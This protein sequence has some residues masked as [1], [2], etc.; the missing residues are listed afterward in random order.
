[1]KVD[2]KKIEMYMARQYMRKQDLARLSGLSSSTITK[3]LAGREVT[4]RSAGLIAKGLGLEVEE[5]LME[6]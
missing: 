4:A 6:G 2:E 5:I 1:M 3:V